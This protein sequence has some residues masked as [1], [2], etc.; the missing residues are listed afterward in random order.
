MG[1]IVHGNPAGVKL[2]Q[3]FGLIQNDPKFK[4]FNL[5]LEKTKELL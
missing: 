4:Q 3:V 5:T 1:K 2:K